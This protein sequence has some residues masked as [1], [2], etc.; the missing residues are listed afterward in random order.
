M[1]VRV[2]EM[3]SRFLSTPLNAQMIAMPFIAK[4]SF[5]AAVD[6]TARSAP[7]NAATCVIVVQADE[8]VS[9][10]V[11]AGTPTASATDYKINAGDERV[12]WVSPGQVLAARTL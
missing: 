11:G 7:F 8:N 3:D 5:N 6:G 10:E 4:Q 1:A 9:V 12:F 2:F